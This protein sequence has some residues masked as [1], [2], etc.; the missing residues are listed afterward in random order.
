MIKVLHVVGAMNRAGAETMI[1][2]YFRC[3]DRKSVQFDFL[4][5]TNDECDYDR[6]IEALGGKIYRIPR[7]TGFNYFQYRNA[8]QTFFREHPEFDIVHGHIGAGAPIYLTAAKEHNVFTIAHAHSENFYTGIEKVAFSVA[9]RPTR[10]I[11]EAFFACSEQAC[12]DTFG[13][14]IFAKGKYRIINNGIF[15]DEY[16]RALDARDVYREQFDLG[17]CLTI[18][19]IGRF[20][21]VK[22]QSFLVDVFSCVVEHAPDAQLLLVGEGPTK[23]AI[24]SKVKQIG[25][26]NQVHFLGIREDIPELLAAMDCFIFPS[27]K[28][29][30][31]V[32]LVE[33]QA[34]GLPTLMSSGIT[35]TAAILPTSRRLA[36]VAGAERWAQ[37]ALNLID[38]GSNRSASANRI[39]DAGF[40]IVQN[41]RELVSLYA[42]FVR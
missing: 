37:E 27:V 5:H 12:I 28:E 4:V 26:E 32:S 35:K 23:H 38:D 13:A 11:A 39:K 10:R 30:L 15:V 17:D 22:N 3:I 16:M 2:N 34:S 31:P 40:D 8:C 1:M 36:L 18:G 29:G 33:A 20:I 42:Q 24:E 6:E 25:L 41:A 9:T 7:F 14:E 21:D 19:H